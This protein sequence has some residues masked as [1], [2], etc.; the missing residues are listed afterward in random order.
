M[1]Y[2]QRNRGRGDTAANPRG[3]TQQRLSADPVADPAHWGSGLLGRLGLLLRLHRADHKWLS[4]RERAVH[5]PPGRQA[6]DRGADRRR[7]DVGVVAGALL[8]FRD[9][10]GL[11]LSWITRPT[12]VVFTLGGIAGLAAWP[13][14]SSGSTGLCTSSTRSARRWP[15]RGGRHRARSSAGWARSRDGCTS[16]ASS[17]WFFSA[18]P[19]SPWRAPAT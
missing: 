15:P 10:S 5:A 9:S 13:T 1:N 6:E 11:D 17:T 4:P 18:S 3:G 7:F 19:F 12:G 2:S 16:L 8:Y 14:A